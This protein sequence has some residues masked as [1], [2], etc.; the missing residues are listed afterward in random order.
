M[1]PGSKPNA[2]SD[3][4]MGRV[5]VCEELGY[6]WADKVA[7]E[8]Y[9]R[10]RLEGVTSCQRGYKKSQTPGSSVTTHKSA[11]DLMDDTG[12][13]LPVTVYHLNDDMLF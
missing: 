9:R 6:A 2:N 13:C 7:S 5:S 12:K 10:G 1:P 3:R 4:S 11:A 8:Y